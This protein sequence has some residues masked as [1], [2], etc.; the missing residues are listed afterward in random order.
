[1]AAGGTSVEA[2]VI[3]NYAAGVE[4][5]KSGAATVNPD[6]VLDAYDEFQERAALSS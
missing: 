4:V 5:G 1:L 6:E 3:A 2:A